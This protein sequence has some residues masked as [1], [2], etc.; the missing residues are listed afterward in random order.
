MGKKSIRENKNLFQISREEAGLTRDGASAIMEFISPDR[1]EK[2]ES[3][4]CEP[5]PDEVLAMSKAYKDPELCNHYCSGCCPI[6][7]KYIPQINVKSLSQITLEMLASL[8]AIEEEKRRLIEITVD[9]EI[10]DD[11]KTDF[12]EIKDKLNS[13]LLSIESLKMWIDDKNLK[14]GESI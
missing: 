4:K 13:I 2:I 11:E 7:Q 12:L 3:E 10:S 1:I 6:G 5:H 9:G 14:E 8:N